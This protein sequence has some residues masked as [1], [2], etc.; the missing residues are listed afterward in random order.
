MYFLLIV[1]LNENYIVISTNDTNLKNT[2]ELSAMFHSSL[3]GYF[4]LFH[5]NQLTYRVITSYIS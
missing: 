4:Q 2:G 5:P 3:D 1:K